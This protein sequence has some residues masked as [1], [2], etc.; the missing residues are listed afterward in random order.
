MIAVVDLFGD[1]VAKTSALC[2]KSIGTKVYYKFGHITEI[3][4]T[5]VSY[6][7]TDEFRKQ[8]YP[9]V[10]LLQD[11]L[12][13]KNTNTQLETE[14]NLQLLIVSE[15]NKDWRSADRYTN[16]FKPV[17]YPIYETLIKVISKDGR[18]Q[19]SYGPISHNKID[20]PLINGF[21]IVVRGA[22]KNLFNDC[23]DA[24]EIN[25]LTLKIKN[26]CIK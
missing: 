26:L 1:L 4:N 16:V 23:L 11:F 14:V 8:K 7:A 6:S 19:N 10:M 5:L 2:E 3:D 22:T 25:N 18:L 13:R 17:L 21:Q 12:E 15:S 20:R 24:I 9:C